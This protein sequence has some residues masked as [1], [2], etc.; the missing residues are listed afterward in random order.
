M[1]EASK[2]LRAPV[3]V[4]LFLIAPYFFVPFSWSQTPIPEIKASY[5]EPEAKAWLLKSP[6]SKEI[7]GFSSS[8]D[9]VFFIDRLYDAGAIYVGI[10]FIK[11]EASGLRIYL[12]LKEEE[13]SEIFKMA[14]SESGRRGYRQQEDEGQETLAVWF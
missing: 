12:P 10:I 6:A 2:R 13:R 7:E 14:R 3:L 5:Q 11:D 4:I 9:A 1:P 8:K